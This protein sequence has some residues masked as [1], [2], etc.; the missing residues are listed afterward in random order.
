MLDF[1][2]TE[3]RRVFTEVTSPIATRY[4]Q[5]LCETDIQKR[6]ADYDEFRKL[7]EAPEQVLMATTLSKLVQG[8]PMPV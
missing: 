6:R 3:R 2:S 1:Y 4:K 5:R 7:A 8:N